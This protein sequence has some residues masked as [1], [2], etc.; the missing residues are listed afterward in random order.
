[1]AITPT[2]VTV[3]GV[4]DKKYKVDFYQREYKWN[5]K[6]QSYRP[7]KSLLDDIFYRFELC[8]DPNVDITEDVISKYDWYYLNSFMT[9]TVGSNTFIVDGQQRLTTLTI[10]IIQLYRMALDFKKN[11]GIITNI[12]NRICNYDNVGNMVFWLGFSDREKAMKN[13]FEYGIQG[14]TKHIGSVSISE[15]NIYEAYE[16]IY[17]YFEEKNI[18]EHMYDAFRLYLLNRIVLIKI[19]VDDSKDVAMAFEVINDRGIPLKSYEILKGKIIGVLDKTEVDDYLNYWQSNINSLGEEF[20]EGE[21]DE[22]LSTYFRSKYVDNVLQY[23]AL[24]E[25]KY[26]KSIYTDEFDKKIGFKHDVNKKYINNVKFFLKETLP[27]FCNLYK[28]IC[29][30][31]YYEEYN[32][33]Y[34]Y[35]NSMNEQNMQIYL[36]LSAIKLNDTEIEAKFNL[37]PKLFDRLYSILNL[38]DS[39]KSNIFNTDIIDLGINIRN[40]E[41]VEIKKIF[42]DK[43][44]SIVIKEHNRSD[45]KEPFKYEYFSMRG[46]NNLGNRFLRYFYARIDG[47]IFNE[48]GLSTATYYE[49]IK[50]AKGK[51]RHH[52]E[53]ILANNDINKRLFKDEEEFNEQRNRLGA[54][55]LL[56]GSDNQSSGNE[57]YNDKLKTYSGNGTLFAQT[58]TD[59][60]EHSNVEFKKFCLKYNLKFNQYNVFDEKS[61]EERQ[62]LIFELSKI[63][64]SID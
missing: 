42:E 3:G 2:E 10:L 7:I 61:I 37:I 8:Y 24:E 13:I 46:Y 30:D 53:H 50:Q 31:Y 6:E 22:F 33:E 56:R 29:H 62:N 1:M 4:F 34:I 64:W 51:N 55:V 18:S 52:I 41:I 47:L 43:L 54:L 63:I 23:R 45:L 20:T 12:S 14:K 59:Q 15:K 26:H 32:N 19:D 21:I 38:T 16:V 5:D 36:I 57:V 11:Q 27:Y 49:M 39:Y 40:K 17:N 9:N 58:L 35:Y 60:F 48:T 44:L 25:S 28:R